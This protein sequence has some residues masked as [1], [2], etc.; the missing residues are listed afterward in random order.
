MSD[1]VSGALLR[2][3]GTPPFDQVQ[4]LQE[5]CSLLSLHYPI[6]AQR[7][8][9]LPFKGCLNLQSREQSTQ[10]TFVCVRQVVL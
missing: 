10:L 8:T 7:H 5:C 1:D 2:D 3:L 6:S 4:A 9:L